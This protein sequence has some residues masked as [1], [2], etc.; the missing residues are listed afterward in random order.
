M[1]NSTLEWIKETV[2]SVFII[3]L[4]FTIILLLTG[5][6]MVQTSDCTRDGQGRWTCQKRGLK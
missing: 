4:V 6:S 3:C 5:C 1:T 2:I